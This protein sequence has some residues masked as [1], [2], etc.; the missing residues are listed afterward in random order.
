MSV[1]EITE[2][3]KSGNLKAAY[4]LAADEYRIDRDNPW[5]QSA[6]FW[7]LR[8][9]CVKMQ[10]TEDINTARK[11]LKFMEKLLPTMKDSGKV[12][13]RAYRYLRSFF[14]PESKVITD[15]S[16]L[17]KTD[18]DN[19]LNL[20]HQYI[21]SP[22]TVDNQMHESLGW[23][24]FRYVK[25]HLTDSK[26]YYTYKYLKEYLKLNIPRPSLLHSQMLKLAVLCNEEQ[27]GWRFL[28]FIEEW[29]TR[30]FM[31]EDWDDSTD[32][33][34]KK[35]PSLAAKT[36]IKYFKLLKDMGGNRKEEQISLLASLYDTMIQ[37]TMPDEW[38]LRQ[39]AIIHL[40]QHQFQ[41]AADIYKKLLLELGD[42]YY[43]W[44][45]MAGCI[46]NDEQMRAAFLS[47]ALLIERHEE[48]IGPIR[49]L[50]ADSLIRQG[51]MS[52]ALFELKQ[53][54]ANKPRLPEVFNRMI[55]SI[56]PDT[57]ATDSNLLF[58]RKLAAKAD[59]FAYS[60][61]P[62]C[63]MVLLAHTIDKK[64]RPACL[65]IDQDG[66][67]TKVSTKRFPIIKN[68]AVNSVFNVKYRTD[69]NT[70]QRIPL[71][72]SKA[73]PDSWNL[74]TARVIV[75][76]INNA[77]QLFHFTFKTRD[78]NMGGIVPFTLTNLRPKIGQCLRITYCIQ[79]KPDDSRKIRTIFVE[80]EQDT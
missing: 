71:M 43:I 21:D 66:S 45:E 36:A 42:K 4:R 61:I 28:E 53:Y 1:K 69:S 78:S 75:D 15:A 51:F 58:Y 68:A 73:T 56:P 9:I 40:W 72:I 64:K 33:N 12:G 74:P 57:K 35:Y 79:K 46:D 49:L 52:E 70:H 14:I 8:D 25:L 2:L 7:V 26:P 16:K 5:A 55:K 77:K 63:S 20:V 3:R 44:S 67:I 48:F 18:P 10:E 80:A 47:K 62:F 60:S 32:N 31:E 54:S 29:D 11:A 22:E 41:E 37:H 39:R 38:I 65:L 27:E 34:G 19:A 13:E 24:L 76:N 59:E 17:S 50:L 30:N 23:I 6:L